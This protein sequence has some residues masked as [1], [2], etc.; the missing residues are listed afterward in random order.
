MTA[1][2]NAQVKALEKAVAKAK[3]VKGR[4]HFQAGALNKI[5]ELKGYLTAAVAK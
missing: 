4:E 1:T 5:R 2:I 3:P